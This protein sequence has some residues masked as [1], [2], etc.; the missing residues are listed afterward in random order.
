MSPSA[1]SGKR[2]TVTASWKAL[3]IQIALSGATAN[4]RPMVGSATVT[5][6]P[7][8]TAMLIAMAR[9]KKASRRCGLASPSCTSTA[10][11]GDI[12][13]G[14]FKAAYGSCAYDVYGAV[15]LDAPSRSRARPKSTS[16]CPWTN[17]CPDATVGS[18]GDVEG[19][20][21]RHC[22]ERGIGHPD[23][24]IGAPGRAK[25]VLDVDGAD[26]AV[27]SLASRHYTR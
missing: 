26:G 2:E 1:A 12:G 19:G 27:R 25:T 18:V 20:S 8:S 15:P 9:V 16:V 14:R 5:M 23:I 10:R 7:S 11:G 24:S 6:V 22:L 13:S 3:T 17:P 21:L 4:W